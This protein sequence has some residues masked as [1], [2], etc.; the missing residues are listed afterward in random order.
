M[1]KKQQIVYLQNGVIIEW[2]TVKVLLQNERF[3]KFH[4]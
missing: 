1:D 2:T 4:E 3:P